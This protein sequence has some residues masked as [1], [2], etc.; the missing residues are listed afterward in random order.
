MADYCIS[1][2]STADLSLKHFAERDIRVIYFHFELGGVSYLD[3]CGISVPPEKLFKDMLDGAPTKTSMVSVGEYTEA[4]EE[5]LSAGKDVLHITLSSGISGTYN[6]ACIA[7]DELAAKYP[8][9]KIY[10]VDSLA[11]SSGFG[12]I[13]D[14]LADLRDEGYTIDQLHDWINEHRLNMNHWFFS[15]DLTFFIR[16]GRVS[17]TAGT[18]GKLLNICPLLNVDNMGRLIPREKIRTKHK[19]IRRTFEKMEECADNGLEYDGKCFISHSAC[20]EDARELADLIEQNFPKLNG[21][22]QIFPIGATI[23]SH[24]GPGTVALFFWGKKRVD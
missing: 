23:G 11:A 3:D 7:R 19:V 18:F 14:T 6:S 8:D 17:K 13:M 12:L 4:F 24:T 20:Y 16:G 2:C 9:R 22:V 1:C 5:A 21:K 15:T 10:V